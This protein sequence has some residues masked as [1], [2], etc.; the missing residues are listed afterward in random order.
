MVGAHTFTKGLCK[1]NVVVKGINDD[2]YLYKKVTT[3]G[4]IIYN[5]KV[6]L[7]PRF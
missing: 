5:H 4:W 2:I 1:L 6:R 7:I 3:F